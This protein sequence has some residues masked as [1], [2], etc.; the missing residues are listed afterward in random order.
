MCGIAGIISRLPEYV[1]PERLRNMTDS[2]AHR[3][4]DGEG[5]WIS[6]DSLIGLGHRRLA[7][8]DLSEAGRQP[9]HFLDRYTII[10]NGEIYNFPELK[11]YLVKKGY[12]FRSKTDTEVIAA[13]YDHFRED[14]IGHFDGMFAFAIW[15][16]K[17]KSLFAA[18]DRFGEKPFFYY[19]DDEQFVFA[20]EIKGL[21]A[22]GLPKTVNQK[23]LFNYLTIGY[24]DNPSRPAET[25][26]ENIYKLPP[27]SSLYMDMHT[28]QMQIRKYW[29]IDPALEIN[30]PGDQKV[31]EEFMTLF[32]TSISRRL[33]S[34]LPVGTS[35]S[36]GLD[37]SSIVAMIEE[38]GKHEHV[39]QSFSAIFPGFEKNEEQYI[40]LVTDRFGWKNNK[41]V[42][43]EKE[44]PELIGKVA[45]HLDEPFGSASNIAQYCVYQSAKDKGYKVLLDGQGA[46]EILAGYTKYY[47]WYWQ[48]LFRQRKLFRSGELKA[49]RQL[50]VTEKFGFK[51][52]VA[53]LFPDLAS[54]ILEQRY[55][56]NAIQHPDLSRDFVREQ[57][58]EAYYN[59]PS[60]GGLNGILYFNTCIHGLEEL[61]RYADRNSMAHGIEVRLPFLQHQLVE[62]LFSLP[63][64]YKIKQ[65]YT[66][67]LLR[68]T[69][70]KHLPEAIVWRKDK[71]G[72]E[73]PQKKW[74]AQKSV[75]DLI[76]ASKEKLVREGIL[77]QEALENK[78]RPHTSYTAGAYEWRYLAAGLLFK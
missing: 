46:D 53:S 27:A 77:R 76:E 3:G 5:Y 62:F 52:I 20:S 71:T 23:M 8:I 18:R 66:K 40:D 41:S 78:P 61:L 63:P 65:G 2:L 15:D 59:K 22:A 72:F 29:S 36:G 16:E 1:N 45:A 25:F 34:D 47:K 37:S 70:N 33:R 30:D 67:R 17:E 9:M 32:S 58:R 21:W 12:V 68:D 39:F 48:E 35:L 26:F 75:V 73:P 51:N 6:P 43:D 60:F 54:V 31:Q 7:I 13:A 55:L 14:C 11:E 44:L 38:T 42:I 24:V 57:S 28:R 56:M 74:M 50:G 69:M 10:H 64:S 49:A 4:P 19:K